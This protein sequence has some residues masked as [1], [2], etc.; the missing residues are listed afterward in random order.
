MNDYT[1]VVGVDKKHLEQLQHTWPTWKKHK[2]S[3]L[4][5]PMV[6]FR[7]RHQVTE[8][9]VHRVVDHP[10]LSVVAWPLDSFEHRYNYQASAQPSKWNNPQRHKM[11]SGFVYVPSVA[12]MTRYWLKIDT[13]TVATGNDDWIDDS[14]F[15][16]CPAIIAQPWPYTK[17]PDQMMKL[18]KWVNDCELDLPMLNSCPPLELRPNPGSGCLR[19]HRI[20]SWCGFFHTRFTAKAASWAGRTGAPGSLPVP[21]QDGYLYYCAKRLG[22]GVVRAGMKKRGWQHWSTMANIKAHSAEAMK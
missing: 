18:D 6:V 22:F 14:W 20:I 10:R 15:D 19:H 4:D 7:D 8:T 1:L 17:P 13:D 12:V 21:S 2:P 3:L 11:L 9:E 5:V 16:N